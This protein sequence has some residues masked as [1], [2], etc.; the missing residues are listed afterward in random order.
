MIDP[1]AF[2]APYVSKR[3]FKRH[4]DWSMLEYVCEENNRNPTVGGVTQVVAPGGRQP[5]GSTRQRAGAAA[6]A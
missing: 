2:T 5:I 3:Y 6:P 1:K 4:R